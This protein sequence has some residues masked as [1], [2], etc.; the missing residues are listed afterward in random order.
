MLLGV[1]LWPLHHATL[2]R[3]VMHLRCNNRLVFFAFGQ[4]G[5]VLSMTAALAALLMAWPNVSLTGMVV[6]YALALLVFQV[7]Q[8]GEGA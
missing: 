5:R 2:V 8:Y 4:V 1:A 7:K 3:T 6:G